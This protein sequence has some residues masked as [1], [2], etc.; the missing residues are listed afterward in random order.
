MRAHSMPENPYE[1][2]NQTSS[3]VSVHVR[4]KLVF[5][6][7]VCLAAFSFALPFIAWFGRGM[8]ITILAPGDPLP[9]GAMAVAFLVAMASVPIAIVGLVA[10]LTVAWMNRS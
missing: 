9:Q 4:N 7:G 8:V 2:P 10:G 1:S 5:K 3:A 6:F